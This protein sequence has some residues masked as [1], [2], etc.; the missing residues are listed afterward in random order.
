MRCYRVV[1]YIDILIWYIFN[2]FFE[3]MKMIVI[4]FYMLLIIYII[5]L[6][7][8]LYFILEFGKLF[9]VENKIF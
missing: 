6:C 7:L 3:N 5:Y 9:W 2:F 4:S 8:F 1:W